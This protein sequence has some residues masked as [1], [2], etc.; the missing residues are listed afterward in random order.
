MTKLIKRTG[1]SIAGSLNGLEQG[2]SL[3]F[4]KTIRETTIRGT[5]TRLKNT[6]GR[7]YRVSRQQDGT[8]IVTRVS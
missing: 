4:P 3:T 6:E 7:I 8:H 5:A 1:V 2:E